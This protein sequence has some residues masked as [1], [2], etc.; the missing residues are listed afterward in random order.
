[1]SAATSIP[2]PQA[3]PVIVP[4]NAV[5]EEF[6]RRL[7]SIS[8]QSAVYF[9][10]TILTA[11]AGYFFKVYLARSLGAEALGL[12]AL[13]M[14]VVGFL[15]LFSSAGLPAAAARFAAEYRGRGEYAR[16]GDFLRGSLAALSAATLLL[17]AVLMLLGP[18]IAVHFYH[19][20]ALSSYFWLFVL[21]MAGGV[22]T[23]FLGQV[24]AGYQ[25][26]ARR[27]LITHFLGTPANI[28]LAV[29]L[30]SLGFGLRGYLAAQIAS[31]LLVAVLLAG[32]V[33]KM[34]PVQARA[35]A[36]F[37]RV[38]KSVAAFSATAFGIAALEFALN[39]ADKIVLGHY[40]DPGQVGVYAVATALVA[41]VPV[42][43]QSVNQIFSPTIAELYAI[44]N[45]A[46]LQQLY[47]TLTKWILIFTLP[48]AFTMLFFSRPLI[49]IFGHGFEAGVTVLMIGAVG[50]LFNCAVG[51]VGY[52]LLMSGHQARL[53]KIQACN[54]VLM[55]I[56]SLFLVPRFGIAGAAVASAIALVAT[57][58]WALM[59][60][61]HR[62][63]LFPYNAGYLK[64]FPAAFISAAA[65]WTLLQVSARIYSPWT[66]SLVGVIGAYSSF[67]G[68]IWLFGMDS[69]D[70]KF[71]KLA[72][73]KLEMRFRTNGVTS[74]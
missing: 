16:L 68:T 22:L 9:A 10:G 46:L 28:I 74:R 18:R 59:V 70:R 12:Y 34:T 51:S 4:A 2:E 19:V 1:M 33:W 55:I 25:D 40:L 42:A 38:E 29:V 8:R 14:S 71:A 7:G 53:I 56:L 6:G 43:L 49:A 5:S 63:R 57:N 31:A 60:V 26:V 69:D 50:Q 44:G 17:G 65:L 54:A 66:L 15:G 62:L 73:S 3:M 37:G 45:H 67:L 41:F 23:T 24:M 58:V 21:I 11:A 47:A 52:L 20:P 48:L 30:I 61:H 39:Q 35:G 64:L 32:A 36:A 13:G 72:W 27:T